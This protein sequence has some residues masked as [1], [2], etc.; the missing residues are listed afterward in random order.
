M[1]TVVGMSSP[2]KRIPR[3]S[4]M[5]RVQGRFDVTPA[6]RLKINEACDLLGISQSQVVQQILEELRIDGGG[7]VFVGRK[8]LL[9]PAE[10]QESLPLT[11]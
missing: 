2:R 6:N 5:N 10:N 7:R 1:A 9:A 4:G 8:R 11:G 3:G